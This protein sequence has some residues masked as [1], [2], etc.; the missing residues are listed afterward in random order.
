M[1]EAREIVPFYADNAMMHCNVHAFH[2]MYTFADG[3][4]IIQSN[5]RRPIDDIPQ[6]PVGYFIIPP[7]AFKAI[8]EMMIL[9]VKHYEDNYEEIQSVRQTPPHIYY[10]IVHEENNIRDIF[11]DEDEE[12]GDE[13]EPEE[14]DV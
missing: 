9:M 6:N 13:D 3:R 11:G 4:S 7:T 8:M 1:A 14:D 10:E 2:M 5:Q 12:D